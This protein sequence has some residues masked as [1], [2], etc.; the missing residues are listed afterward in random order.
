MLPSWGEGLEIIT[1]PTR[2]CYT[3][4]PL[5]A[6]ISFY[7]LPLI[8]QSACL[9]CP[10]SK[11]REPRFG[12]ATHVNLYRQA[13]VSAPCHLSAKLPASSV[14]IPKIESPSSGLSIIFDYMCPLTGDS[15]L[16]I[17]LRMSCMK[18]QCYHQLL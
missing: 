1:P 12:G 17:N 14:I 4:K 9:L 16:D 11:N 5:S 13:L 7:S 15:I 2:G 6:G 10:H 18:L 8:C 3:R